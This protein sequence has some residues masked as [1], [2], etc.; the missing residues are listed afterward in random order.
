MQT[1]LLGIGSQEEI[2][3]AKNGPLWK[4]RFPQKK[5]YSA[6]FKHCSLVQTRSLSQEG[7]RQPTTRAP[8]SWGQK[9]L[10][11]EHQGNRQ[12]AK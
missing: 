8:E 4:Q 7:L 2:V 3:Q 12:A 5:L 6:I 11:A 10:Q 9:P 1:L